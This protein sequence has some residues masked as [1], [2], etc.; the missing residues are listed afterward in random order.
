MNT[1]YNCN[2]KKRTKRE[3][4]RLNSFHV[5]NSVVLSISIWIHA[6]E[7]KKR[8][9]KGEKRQQSPLSMPEKGRK[10]EREAKWIKRSLSKHTVHG[11]FWFFFHILI[12]VRFV[13][14]HVENLLRYI[15]E[16]CWY[17]HC[18]SIDALIETKSRYVCLSKFG[19]FWSCYWNMRTHTHKEKEKHKHETIALMLNLSAK[20][21]GS[22]GKIIYSLLQ[23]RPMMMMMLLLTM[24]MM[25]NYTRPME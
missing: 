18:L 4:H 3:H 16:Q 15:S 1:N 2:N 20:C 14:L 6:N 5:F 23:T 25:I 19:I 24:S 13:G 8:R 10:R 22:F 11:R 12:F 7:C 21:N 9:K 17:T